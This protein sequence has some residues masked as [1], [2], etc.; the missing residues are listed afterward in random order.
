MKNYYREK[1]QKKIIQKKRKK[2]E[3]KKE[4]NDKAL[5][6]AYLYDSLPSLIAK[7]NY[8]KH[9]KKA[10][11]DNLHKLN[12]KNESNINTKI[13]IILHVHVLMII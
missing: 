7:I 3:K 6:L 5:A 1:K 12:D 2:R 10:C 13:N 11:F 4:N 9:D 8:E